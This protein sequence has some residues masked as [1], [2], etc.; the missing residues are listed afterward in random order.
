MKSYCHK[1]SGNSKDFSWLEDDERQ[2][3]PI[4]GNWFTRRRQRL[5]NDKWENIKK[6]RKKIHQSLYKYF[7][8]F[9]KRLEVLAAKFVSLG[10]LNKATDM[11]YLTLEEITSFEEGRLMTINL[12][13]LVAYRTEEYKTYAADEKIP[14]IWLTIGLVGLAEKYQSVI[15]IKDLKHESISNGEAFF[16]SEITMSTELPLELDKASRISN[17]GSFMNLSFKEN[18]VKNFFMNNSKKNEQVKDLNR[19]VLTNADTPIDQVTELAAV[20]ENKEEELFKET[21]IQNIQI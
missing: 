4:D 7:D 5:L 21:T 1:L 12:Q 11:F 2:F 6:S 18:F 15:S 10:I 13:N 8:L 20:D 17:L 14:Q 9:N 19:L 3:V 16:D